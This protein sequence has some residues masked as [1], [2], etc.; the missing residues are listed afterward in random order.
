MN[1]WRPYNDEA[2][3]EVDPQFAMQRLVAKE[4]PRAFRQVAFLGADEQSPIE[5]T[6]QPWQRRDFLALDP[7]WEMLADVGPQ[8]VRET[9]RRRAYVERPRGHSKTTDTAVQLA[10]ILFASA[11]AVNGL[12]AAADFEQAKLIHA[13]LR[14]LARANEQL[15]GGLTFT[16]G[17]VRNSASGSVLKVISSD[18]RGSWGEL[19][20]FVVCD[21]LCHWKSPDLWQSL[22][23]SAAKRPNSVLVVLS[24]AGF[25]R[26]WQWEV[27][28]GARV[29]PAWY[30]STLD[31]P[32]APWITSESLDEQRRL[33][34]P[35]VYARLWLNQWQHSDGEFV[36]LSEAEAC[37]DVSLAAREQATPGRQYVAAIDYAEKRDLTV[38]C[39]CHLEGDAVVVDRMDVVRPSPLRPTP[40]QWVEDWMH[41][42]AGGFPGVQFILD[43]YQ[44]ASTIQ[45]LECCYSVR[46]FQF[47]SGEGNHRIAM[48]LRQLILQR[49]LRWYAGC[50]TVEGEQERLPVDN[51]ETELASLIVREHRSGRFRFDHLPGGGHHD[52]RAF[53]LGV[54][55][56]AFLSGVQESARLEFSLPRDDG[57]LML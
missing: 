1:F 12:A 15:L 34:P 6:L 44:L 54:A 46:R 27:R 16:E 4:S 47:A 13:A 49:R 55:C 45:R 25:G 17:E 51:L 3:E 53:A 7:A 28:E 42:I 50:G 33:L 39:V 40:V 22:L 35:P 18:V 41:R 52:D 38:G 31:G 9:I 57:T 43:E 11:R 48:A 21:E 30:F 32:Q 5:T 26:D 10:W 2:R 36:S 24:N 19:P 14:R 37:R 8:L 23:S 20:D 29:D 56:E